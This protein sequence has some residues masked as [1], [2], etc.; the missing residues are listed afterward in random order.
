MALPDDRLALQDLLPPVVIQHLI[1]RGVRTTLSR[2]VMST[3]RGFSP[4]SASGL[5]AGAGE[6]K[7]KA[8]R[9]KTSAVAGNFMFARMMVFWILENYF[10]TK[11]SVITK[12]FIR[13]PLLG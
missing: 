12:A 8:G 7:V 9:S 4:T 2:S 10:Q 6:P 1:S 13:E 11:R 5:E 3:W